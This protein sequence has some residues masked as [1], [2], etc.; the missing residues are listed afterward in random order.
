LVESTAQLDGQAL[1]VLNTPLDIGSAGDLFDGNAD[2]LIRGRNANPLV[3]E[4]RF[5]QPRGVNAIGLHLATMPRFQIRIGLTRVDAT[6]A[7]LTQ[8]YRDLPADPHIELSIPR[9]SSQVRSVRI[10]IYDLQ[11]ADDGPHI[12]VRDIQVR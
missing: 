7:S 10:E 2:T 4:L 6:T 12:H 8:N 1:T 11:P 5:A 3:L 9:G